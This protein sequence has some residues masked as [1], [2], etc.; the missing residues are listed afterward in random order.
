MAGCGVDTA[1]AAFCGHVFGQ[2]DGGGAVNKRVACFQLFELRAEVGGNRL[3]IFKT[4]LL[5]DGF[6]QRGGHNERTVRW[7]FYCRIF[8]IRVDSDGEIGR[9]RPGSRCPDEDR[10]VLFGQVQMGARLVAQAQFNENGDAIVI[11]V[12]DLGFG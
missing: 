1:S 3:D 9:Q 2:Q 10:A 7:C 4:A 5:D 8:D 6:E 12:F 11:F